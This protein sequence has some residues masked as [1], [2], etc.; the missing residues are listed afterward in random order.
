MSMGCQKHVLLSV[1][2]SAIYVY[3]II[4]QTLRKYEFQDMIY[5]LLYLPY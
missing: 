2:L 5:R 1:L 3:R 4:L